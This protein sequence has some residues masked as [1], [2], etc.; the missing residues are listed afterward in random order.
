MF[1][2]SWNFN[3]GNKNTTTTKITASPSI[4]VIVH[5]PQQYQHQ[6]NEP[7]KV[8]DRNSMPPEI[9]K[10]RSHR[11]FASLVR[12]ED[13]MKVVQVEKIIQLTNTVTDITSNNRKKTIP[14]LLEE[15][16]EKNTSPLLSIGKEKKKL[17][18][19]IKSGRFLTWE[20]YEGRMGNQLNQFEWIFRVAKAF[21]RT[22]VI[23]TRTHWEQY[24]GIPQS[25]NGTSYVWDFN[26]FVQSLDLVFEQDLLNLVGFQ[27]PTLAPECE[28]DYPSARTP[29]KYVVDWIEKAEKHSTCWFHIHFR[30]RNGLVSAYRSD[31]R[32]FGVDQLLFWR[33]LVP[34]QEIMTQAQAMINDLP[35]PDG[36]PVIG[37]HARTWREANSNQTKATYRVC[38][39]G[40]QKKK[41]EAIEAAHKRVSCGLEPLASYWTDS[42]A[43]SVWE[44]RGFSDACLPYTASNVAKLVFRSEENLK[45]NGFVVATDHERSEID[46]DFIAMG[47]RFLPP[48]PKAT[49]DDRIFG[50]VFDFA[51]MI[52]ADLFYGS[53]TSTLT[54]AICFWRRALRSDFDPRSPELCNLLWLSTYSNRCDELV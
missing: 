49:E 21:N 32:R 24:I 15:S 19:K 36:L 25:R 22:V 13:F 44:K 47:G 12:N 5:S 6:Q 54:Q 27:F 37:L 14:G 52:K 43:R 4:A 16:I 50:L 45:R 39:P 20:F 40:T 11:D 46:E 41:D 29:N 18:E 3:Q 30:S 26:R 2:I 33:N 8:I 53:P 1:Y 48:K 31:T 42:L 34:K 23:P 7:S 38:A 17:Q 51:L 35:N 28:W 10:Q 9:S